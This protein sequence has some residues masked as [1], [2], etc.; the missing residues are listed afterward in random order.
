MPMQW[1]AKPD[2]LVFQRISSVAEAA[3]FLRGKY[4][5]IIRSEAT[6]RDGFKL[7]HTL[8]QSSCRVHVPLLGCG[9]VAVCLLSLSPR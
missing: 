5:Y 7:W 6:S 3:T 9:F 2:N 8:K 1:K 4:A